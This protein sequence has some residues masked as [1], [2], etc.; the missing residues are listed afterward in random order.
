MKLN[1]L[2]VGDN[3]I[4]QVNFNDKFA[5]FPSVVVKTDK[6]GI[7]IEAVKVNDKVVGFSSANVAIDLYNV[8]AE[9]PPMIWKRVACTTVTVGGKVQYYIVASGEGYESNRREAFRLFVGIAGIA[10]LG[11]NK[12]AVDVIVKDVSETGFSFVSEYDMGEIINSPVRLVFEDMDRNYSLMG[13]VVRKVIIAERK[14]VYG[15]KLSVENFELV[16]Y[17]NFKQRQQLQMNK[18][19]AASRMRDQ[20]QQALAEGNIAKANAAAKLAAYDGKSNLKPHPN[21]GRK[22]DT[23]ND[24][25]ERRD[26]FKDSH[27][28]KNL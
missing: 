28:G 23:V 26:V 10:Q 18:D 20:L 15:C 17:I 22:I 3:V 21:G 16:R 7:F 5:D 24:K 8:R 4:L 19:N 11:V 9:K 14:I 12:K 13:I 2:E 1:E 27:S 6:E 25:S